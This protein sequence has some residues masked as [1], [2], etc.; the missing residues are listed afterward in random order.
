MKKKLL[1][2]FF[3][4]FVLFIIFL[5]VYYRIIRSPYIDEERVA[6]E[7]MYANTNIVK[8]NDTF[9]YHGTDAYHVIEGIDE[10]GEEKIVWV[11]TTKGEVIVR[12]KSDGLT[13]EAV[14]QFALEKLA[15]EKIIS[16]RLGIEQQLPVYEITYLDEEGRYAYYYMTFKNGTFVK[17][18]S[19]KNEK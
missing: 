2:I 11:D 3:V 8:V 12:N 1:F 14:K 17:R 9:F 10:D 4:L 7:V 6:L 16:I 19:L 5:I 15:A 18:Y 13:K